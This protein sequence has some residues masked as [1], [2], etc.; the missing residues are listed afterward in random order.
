MNIMNI[1]QINLKN[2][3]NK[4][5]IKKKRFFSDYLSMRDNRKKI[6]W[7]IILAAV[8]VGGTIFASSS[9]EDARDIVDLENAIIVKGITMHS[10]DPISEEDT[11]RELSK[12]DKLKGKIIYDDAFDKTLTKKSNKK[13]SDSSDQNKPKK[14]ES[15]EKF[16]KELKKSDS[17]YH[18]IEYTIKEGD[19]LWKIARNHNCQ[20]TDIIKLNNIKNANLL[21]KGKTILIPSRRGAYHTVQKGDTVSSLVKTYNMDK[22][23]FLEVNKIKGSNI[24][25]GQQLF[26]PSVKQTNTIAKARVDNARKGTEPVKVVKKGAE[27][28]TVVNAKP[29]QKK[30][31]SEPVR[32][33]NLRPQQ[34]TRNIPKRELENIIQSFAEF[35]D[36]ESEPIASIDSNTTEDDL[37]STPIPVVEKVTRDIAFIMPVQGRI[38]SGFGVRRNPL[39]RSRKAQTQFHS[40]IDIAVNEGTPIKASESGVVVFSGWKDGYGN[41]VVIR[42]KLG[43]FT[44]YAHNS[45]N[46]R[47]ENDHVEQGDIIALSGSTGAVTGPHLH[48]EIRKYL[49]PLNPIR[50][51]R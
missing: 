48:F 46:L 20:H 6:F 5:N 14:A 29:Q 23:L 12:L 13:P 38:S 19:N 22:K 21:S 41:L 31:G 25:I 17:K 27:P 15:K 9:S 32:V 7:C 2:Q 30:T 28:R 26:L 37:E 40:G 42:H 18:I 10:S 45:K 8:V 33:E 47:S 24:K 36:V 3:K 1:L 34:T 39:S 49:T 16:V 50:M 11:D 4:Q 51:I 43:Y 35:T 44:I